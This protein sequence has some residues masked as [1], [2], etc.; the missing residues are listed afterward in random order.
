MKF[1]RKTILTFL[2]FTILAGIAISCNSQETPPPSAEGSAEATSTPKPTVEVAWF[3]ATNDPGPFFRFVAIIT[4]PDKR[5]IAGIETEWVAYDANNTIVGSIKGPR[6]VVPPAD[7]LEYVGGAGG[8]NLSGVPAKVVVNIVDSGR[9]VDNYAPHFAVSK[10]ELK[11]DFFPNEYVVRAEITTGSEEVASA[12]IQAYA[13]LKNAN[14]AIVGAEFWPAQGLPEK[15]PAHTA[16]TAQIGAIKP[17]D[18]P[19]S[20]EVV[21]FADK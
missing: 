13:L 20:A 11:P 9:F 3:S 21:S 5:A 18:K 12:D 2:G 4:N 14:G 16:F 15:V 7:T 6:P 10:V 1:S 17:T 19:T 8:A